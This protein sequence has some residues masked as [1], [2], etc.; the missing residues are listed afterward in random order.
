MPNRHLRGL[1]AEEIYARWQERFE[2]VRLELTFLFSIRRKFQQVE[3]MFQD[4]ARLNAIGSQ[5]WE[6]LL[7]LWGRDAVMAV[8][9]E[10]DDDTNTI[11]LGTLLDEMAARPEI[12]TRR[13]YM[14]HMTGCDQMVVK[15]N[16][17]AFTLFGVTRSATDRMD[18]YL[19]PAGIRADRNALDAAAKPVLDYANRMVAHR[20]PVEE[21]AMSVA[22]IHA[23]LDAMEPVVKKYH[24]ILS[25]SSLMSIEPMEVGD[26]WR[27]AFTFPWYGRKPHDD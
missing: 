12:L 7:L 21:L 15:S 3:A 25:G 20:T 22:D 13:R 24:V 16:D 14:A 6:W 26:D 17:E 5:A 10:L 19:D 9:R 11:S 27:E 23:A 18:D 8:R 1:S 4:N 2:R